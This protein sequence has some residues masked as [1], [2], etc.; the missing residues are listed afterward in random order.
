M[1]LSCG[2][3]LVNALQIYLD[4][5]DRVRSNGRK[6]YKGKIPVQG[7]YIDIEGGQKLC[8]DLGLPPP[9]D[10]DMNFRIVALLTQMR[11]MTLFSIQVLS[12]TLTLLRRQAPRDT[13]L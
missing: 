7:T 8:H 5:C 3:Q 10:Y 9:P 13:E 2:R 4:F 12:S 1:P 6:R 11:G